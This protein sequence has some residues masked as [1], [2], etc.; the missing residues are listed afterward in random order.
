MERRRRARGRRNARPPSGAFTARSP[1]AVDVLTLRRAAL[2]QEDPA[3]AKELAQIAEV[4]YREGEVGIL[5][6]LDAVRTAARA[7]DRAIDI[8]LDARL[9]QIALERVV[10]EPLWP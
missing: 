1:G 2:A 8:R 7:R 5:E 10:G 6:L 3:A 9:A 4:A